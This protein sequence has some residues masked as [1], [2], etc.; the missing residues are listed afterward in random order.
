[1]KLKENQ[2]LKEKISNNNNK[3][4]EYDNKIQEMNKIVKEYE[5]K[6]NSLNKE[7]ELLNSKY[8]DVLDQLNTLL[9]NQKEKEQRFNESIK[10]LNLNNNLLHLINMD[11]ADIICIIIIYFYFN[12]FVFFNINILYLSI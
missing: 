7:K 10:K 11:K 2:N 5:K 8:K 1:M 3:I 9:L 12:F 4:Y 6:I